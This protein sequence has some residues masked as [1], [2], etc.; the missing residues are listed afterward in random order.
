M[1]YFFPLGDPSLAISSNLTPTN[2]SLNSIG[3]ARVAVD[4]IN[5]GL[6]P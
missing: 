5:W 4:K 3:L 2:F 1:K 6:E